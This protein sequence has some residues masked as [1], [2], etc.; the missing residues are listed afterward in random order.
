MLIQRC[1][2]C[3]NEFKW[4]TIMKSI[5]NGY[6]PIEC[7]NCET[8]HYLYFVYH[9]ISSALAVLPILFKESLFNLFGLYAALIYFIWISI[10]VCMSPFYAR[11]HIK[12]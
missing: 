2:N 8:K 5:S 6:E 7:D 4:K 9:L 1:K 10:V 12:K 11:Y 3:S